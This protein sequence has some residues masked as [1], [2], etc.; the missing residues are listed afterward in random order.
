MAKF[1]I[2]LSG[3]GGLVQSFAQS[4][5][6]MYVAQEGQIVDGTYNPMVRYGYMSPPNGTITSVTVDNALSAIPTCS[7]YDAINDDFYIA[8]AGRQIYRG[9]TTTDTSLTRVIQLADSDATIKDMEIYMVNGVRKLFTLYQ[10]SSDTIEIAISSLPYDTGTDNETF[11]GTAGGDAIGG[12]SSLGELFMVVADNGLSYIFNENQVHRFD[13]TAATGGTNGT[14]KSNVLLFPVGYRLVD[15]VDYRG[16]LFI[17][18]HQYSADTRSNNPS[19]FPSGNLGCGVYVWDRVSSISSTKDFYPISGANRIDKLYVNPRGEMMAIVTNTDGITEIR[20]FNGSSFDVVHKVGYLEYPVF[21][22]SVTTMG[23]FMVFATKNGNVFAY[24]AILP[25]DEMH[26]YK[27]LSTSVDTTTNAMVL[28]PSSGTSGAAPA[29]YLGYK[30]SGGTNTLGRWKFFNLTGQFGAS[31]A[32]PATST[33]TYPMYFLP[34]MSTIQH[35]DLYTH[36]ATGSGTTSVGTVD[37]YFNQSNTAWAQKTVTLD[38]IAKGYKRIEI[39]SPY[40]NSIQLAV[41]FAGSTT[42]STSNDMCPAFAII[43]Y[44]PGIAKG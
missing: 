11:T 4:T 43:E 7:L 21:R 19:F 15:A 29:L 38:D 9:D 34:Q 3:R 30:T 23:T 33:V 28:L 39:N 44:V 42:L 26:L 40:V 41:T 13:G 6:N 20:K 10:D 17:G 35:I 36:R 2:D 5:R 18:V 27:L 22:D 14:M 37:I 31:E 32:T 12:N 16:S 25:G 24:G 8:E 1:A